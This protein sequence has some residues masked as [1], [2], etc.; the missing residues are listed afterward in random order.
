M[1]SDDDEPAFP[2]C[3]RHEQSSI[4]TGECVS[5]EVVD[6]CKKNE[7]QLT[8]QKQKTKNEELMHEES[9]KTK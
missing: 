3:K 6:F 9:S 2:F 1:G 7:S 8:G 5:N 4:M